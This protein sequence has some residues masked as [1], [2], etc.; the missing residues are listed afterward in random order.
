MT[1]PLI[2]I[3]NSKGIRISKQ[4][5]EKCGFGDTVELRVQKGRL[6]ISPDRTPRADWEAKFERASAGRPAPA[7]VG[8]GITN[9]FDGA[10]WEW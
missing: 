8:E 10:E 4:L 1:V 6:V 3:G 9:D 5:I 2:N 7:L